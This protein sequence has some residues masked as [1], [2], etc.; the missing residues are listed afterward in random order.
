VFTSD[1]PC[2]EA[3]LTW[4]ERYEQHNPSEMMHLVNLVLQ[5]CGSDARVTED[6]IND[7]DS[8]PDKLNEIQEE[9]KGVGSYEPALETQAD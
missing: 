2:D 3:A 9:E 8:I 7:P 4:L 6:D 5:A 1:T